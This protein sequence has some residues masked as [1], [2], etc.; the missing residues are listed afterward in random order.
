MK[1]RATA[2]APDDAGKQR[3]TVTLELDKRLQ[4]YANHVENVDFE[5]ARTR[6]TLKVAGESVPAEF[7]YP[8]GVKKMLTGIDT[9]WIYVGKV[10]FEATVQRKVGDSAPLEVAVW[11]SGHL[12]ESIC[13]LPGVVRLTVP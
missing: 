7:Q 13:L 3:V 4:I 6:M 9:F 1:V 11:M 12:D 5:A 8:K 10:T 2:T